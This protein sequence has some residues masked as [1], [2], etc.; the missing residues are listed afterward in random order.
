MQNTATF[1]WRAV[2]GL[3]LVG[4]VGPAFAARPS[5]F[6]D[7]EVREVVRRI[8]DRAGHFRKHLDSALDRMSK[9]TYGLCEEN[10]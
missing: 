4:L 8:D 5:R 10:R 1:P 2:L 3:A 9:G 6:S 7:R